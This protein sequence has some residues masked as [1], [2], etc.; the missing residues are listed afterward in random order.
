MP[1][2]IME[3]AAAAEAMRSV[4]SVTNTVGAAITPDPITHTEIGITPITIT[5]PDPTTT[6]SLNPTTTVTIRRRSPTTT[7][8]SRPK[9]SISSSGF[10]RADPQLTAGPLDPRHTPLRYSE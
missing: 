3:I 6:T 2:G 5:H 1:T 8:R 7:H 9:A 4:G 10:D